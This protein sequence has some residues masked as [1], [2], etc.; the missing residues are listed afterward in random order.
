MKKLLSVLLALALLLACAAPAL[1]AD[2]AATAEAVIVSLRKVYQDS[3]ALAYNVYY[4]AAQD[5]Y[6]VLLYSD[7]LDGV[8][9]AAARGGADDVQT[10]AVYKD[11]MLATNTLAVEQLKAD[12]YE[13]REVVLMLAVERDGES[14]VYYALQNTDEI[15]NRIDAQ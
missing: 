6:A 9:L 12:G 3:A 5:V 13:G 8:A 4:S 10:W 7:A 2:D 15:L 1:A 14:A 11:A